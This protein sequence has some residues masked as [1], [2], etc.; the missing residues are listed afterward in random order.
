MTW[1]NPVSCRAKRYLP[2]HFSPSVECMLKLWTHADKVN[3]ENSNGAKPDRFISIRRALTCSR[4]IANDK[5]TTGQTTPTRILFFNMGIP[6]G[7]TI[8]NGLP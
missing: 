6:P 8:R 1:I 3:N 2:L 4:N 7:Y 5:R